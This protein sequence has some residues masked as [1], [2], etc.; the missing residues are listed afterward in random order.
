MCFILKNYNKHE[1]G[2][3]KVSKRFKRHG[4]DRIIYFLFVMIFMALG[5][6]SRKYASYLP[7]AVSEYAGDVI[8]AMM[9]YF[10]FAFIFKKLDVA[11]ITLIALVFSFSIEFSQLYQEPWINNIRNT[12]IGAL[13]LGH[14]FLYTDLICYTVGIIFAAL[15]DKIKSK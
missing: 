11:V 6:A 8:W 2:A 9:V 10:G 15:F 1:K 14:G 13:V 7:A 5:L 12:T 4:R 3:N